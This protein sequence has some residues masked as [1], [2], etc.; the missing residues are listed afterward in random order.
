M[1]ANTEQRKLAA[2]M[3]TDMVGYSALA[4]CNEQLAL[5]L[6]EEHRRLLRSLFPRFNGTEVKTIGDAFLVEFGSAL[7]AAQCAIE[8]QRTLAKRNTDVTPDR[9]IELKIGIHIGDV[10]HRGGDVYGDGVN[11]ASRIEPLAGPSGICISM[12]VERQI[13]HALEASLVKLPPTE[14][15]NIQ[16]PMDLFR[17]VLPW[18]KAHDEV[19]SQKAEVPGSRGLLA[20]AAPRSP[21]TAALLVLTVLL[22]VGIGGWLVR[23]RAESPSSGKTAKRITSLAVKPLDDYSGDTNNA[24]L[25]DGMTEALCSALGNISA[26]R[27]PGRSSVMRFKGGQKSIREMGKELGVDALIEGSVQ[28]AGNRFLVTVQLI[29]AATDRHLWSTNYKRDLSDFFVVQDEVARAIAAEI[30]VR[31]TPEDQTR[32]ARAR[33]VNREAL[34]AY[35]LGMRHLWQ[36]SEEGYTRALRHFQQA[37]QIDPNYAPAHAGAALAYEF[38]AFWSGP[39][40]EM[41]KCKQAA[42]RAIELDPFSVDAYLARG[43]ARMSFD[44]DWPGA[45][46]D[47]R[48]GLQLDPKSSLAL[49]AYNNYLV[50]LGRFEQAL[51]MLNKALESDPLSPGLHSD[52]GGTYYYAGQPDRAIPHLL[53]ALELDP[54]FLQAHFYLGWCYLFSG[55]P[56]EALAEFKATLQLAPDWPWAKAALGYAYGVTGHRPEAMQVLADL[57]ELGRKRYVTRFAQVFLHLGLGQKDAALDWLEKACKEQDGYM[58]FLKTDP[59]FAPLRSEPHFRELLKKVGLD[60]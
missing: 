28:R 30:Q 41:L 27:V 6:L 22:V 40:R 21:R 36:W 32:L 60:K 33:P 19:P 44:W 53:K 37:I 17:I 18:E 57:D 29:E 48:R 25:S 24:Y 55:K 49:D 51:A 2:I 56:A 42:Q 10:V 1:S 7:E 3:F 59:V 38:L 15:K 58:T 23:H 34:E 12:D 5:E 4:Q 39:P 52:V 31:L 13:R 35:L 9:R 54:N 47:F 43:W 50:P 26:L 45:D 8:I 20:L 16:V 14:L 11:I 46:S